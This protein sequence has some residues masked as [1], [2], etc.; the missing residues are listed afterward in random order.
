M[1]CSVVADCELAVKKNEKLV[2]PLPPAESTGVPVPNPTVNVG[3]VKSVES[4]TAT[5]KASLTVTVHEIISLTRTNV[6]DALTCPRHASCDDEVADD[7]FIT[8]GLPTIGAVPVASFSVICSVVVGAAGA[9]K[10]NVKPA[11]LPAMLNAGVPVPELMVGTVKSPA[12]A[13]A[14]PSA[15]NTVTVH[16]INS[17]TRTTVPDVLT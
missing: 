17:L 5:P 7:T 11:P 3:A 12:T 4:A 14:G 16:E 10:K 13:I 8:N 9:V 1:I 6:V 15:S 2:P